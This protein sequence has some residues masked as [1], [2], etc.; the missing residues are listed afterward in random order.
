MSGF[1]TSSGLDLDSIF[2]LKPPAITDPSGILIGQLILDGIETDPLGSLV[3]PATGFKIKKTVPIVTIVDLAD[4]YKK[5]GINTYPLNTEFRISNNID[6]SDVFEWGGYTPS[7][8]TPITTVTGRT[9]S[10]TVSGNYYAVDISS[11]KHYGLGIGGNSGQ[12][13]HNPYTFRCITE[14]FGESVTFYVF[15][16]N[17]FFGNE[18]FSTYNTNTLGPPQ[19]DT[20]TLVSATDSNLIFTFTGQRYTKIKYFIHFTTGDVHVFTTISSLYPSS[21]IDIP[22]PSGN[23]SF[24]ISFIPYNEFEENG[25]ST[26]KIITYKSQVVDHTFADTVIPG[27]VTEITPAYLYSADFLI[28]GGGGSGGAG[29]SSGSSSTVG[30]G[31]GGSGSGGY[32]IQTGILFD[33]KS[34]RRSII[35]TC[36]NGGVGVSGSTAGN[37]GNDGNDGSDSSISF[38]LLSIPSFSIFYPAILYTATGGKKGIGGGKS[39]SGSIGGDAGTPNGVAGAKGNDYG[40]GGSG[41]KNPL[42]PLPPRVNY[43]QGSDGTGGATIGGT[44]GTLAGQN[45]FTRATFYYVVMT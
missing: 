38:P 24:K 30:G 21:T 7:I 33:G 5:K 19:I 39:G 15:I 26:D 45:G 10:I 35:Y 43:G 14:G 1:I 18:Q 36:G 42:P 32:N 44:Q 34:T 29:G 12:V 27:P 8:V 25:P 23:A 17:G 4:H 16:Y 40:T 11:N 31:G 6:L 3:V 41:G 28:V 37:N 2:Q 20:V 9:A 22:I 13:S